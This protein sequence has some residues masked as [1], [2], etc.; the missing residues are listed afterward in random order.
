GRPSLLPVQDDDMRRRDFSFVSAYDAAWMQLGRRLRNPGLNVPGGRGPSLR[1]RALP[2]S[3]ALSLAYRFVLQPPVNIGGSGSEAER[4]LPSSLTMA[5]PA[6]RS[7]PYQPGE[8]GKWY[9]NFDGR[10]GMPLRAFVV[11]RNPV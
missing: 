7:V 6:V 10:P 3:E 9:G 11:A 4:D 5:N 1:C 8:V 2:D